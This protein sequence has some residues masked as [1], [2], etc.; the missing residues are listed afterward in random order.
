MKKCL[1]SFAT[2]KTQVKVHWASI[3]PS[4]EGL[5]SRRQ[6]AMNAGKDVEESKLLQAASE[7][8]NYHNCY[9]TQNSDSPP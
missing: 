3:S 5:S 9:G 7:Y 1:T 4:S 8:I 6:T 2:R